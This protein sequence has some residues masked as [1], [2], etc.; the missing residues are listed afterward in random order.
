MSNKKNVPINYFSRDFNSIKR[1]LVE[2]TKRY[3]PDSYKDFNELGFGSLMLDTVS[4]IGDVLSFYLDY[5]VN[6]SFLETA[7]ERKNIL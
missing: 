5:Q 6:E 2:H 4:Y 1:S 3:Y 7:T